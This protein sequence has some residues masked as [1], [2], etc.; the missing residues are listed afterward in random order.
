MIQ[1]LFGHK[2]SVRMRIPKVIKTLKIR[3]TGP[4]MYQ[5][6]DLVLSTCE[7]ECFMSWSGD[8]DGQMGRVQSW[9]GQKGAVCGGWNLE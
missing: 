1:C 7:T 5:C 3:T 4:C 9:E 6:A 2:C 8:T